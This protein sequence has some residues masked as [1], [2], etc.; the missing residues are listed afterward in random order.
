MQDILNHKYVESFDG[1]KIHYLFKK[2]GKKV[3]FFV[4]GLFGDVT[5][6]NKLNNYLLN[7][8]YTFIFMDS[9]AHGKSGKFYDEKLSTCSSITKDIVAILNKENIN[10]I[11]IV[12]FSQGTV[13]SILLSLNYPDFVEKQI[14]IS[15]NGSFGDTMFEKF[16]VSVSVL[17]TAILYY[18]P[19]TRMLLS[20]GKGKEKDFSNVE[21]VEDYNFNIVEVFSALKKMRIGNAYNFLKDIPRV[22]KI[23]DFQKIKTPTL[24]L[25]GEKDSCFFLDRVKLFNKIVKSSKLVVLKGINH[26]PW[27]NCPKKLAQEIIKYIEND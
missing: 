26:H 21:W 18:F 9:R 8:N 17:P 7:E 11:N 27:N 16:L 14:L 12:G 24:L 20:S 23:G 5:G 15:S 19:I 4:H 10:K 22:L 2:G 25:H 6:W 3:L 13:S 1:T